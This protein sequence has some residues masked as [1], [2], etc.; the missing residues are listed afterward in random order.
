MK[1]N[2]YIV[3]FSQSTQGKYHPLI[4][5]KSLSICNYEN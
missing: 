2:P 3:K 4:L 5:N 1:T